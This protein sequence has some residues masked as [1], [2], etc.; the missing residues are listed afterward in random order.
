MLALRAGETVPESR[1]I[2]GVWGDDTPNMVRNAMQV[3]VAHWRRVLAEAG[4]S[5]TI[6][7]VGAGYRLSAERSAIDVFRFEAL[8]SRARAALGE[9]RFVV[10]V[11]RYDE[12]LGLWRGDPLQD[13]VGMPFHLSE[14][15]SLDG[16]RV[17]ALV[18]RVE[19][20]IGAGEGGELVGALEGLVVQYP[21]EERF[22]AQLMHALYRAGRQ[23]DALRAYEQARHD[24][25]EI[26]V[27]AG[28]LLRAMEQRILQQDPLLEASRSPFTPTGVSEPISSL[29]GRD[30]EVKDLVE[31]LARGDARVVTL[32]GPGGVGKSRLA[33]E[34]ANR[35]Q[36]EG[37]MPVAYV[38]VSENADRELLEV[39]VNTA[40]GVP[41]SWR[42]RPVGDI[43][44]MLGQVPV[45]VVLDGAEHVV[46]AAQ[47]VV[48]ELLA[49]GRQIRVLVASRV[50]LGLTGERQV[51]VQPL[52]CRVPAGTPLDDA[53]AV[54]LFVDR[55]ARFS[56]WGGFDE[57]SLGSIAEV[58]EELD[59]LPLA[60]ELAAARVST[61]GVEGLLARLS[62]RLDVVASSRTSRDTRH[63]SLREVIRW[64]YD[65]LSP[66]AQELFRRLSI[67]AGE[68]SVLHAEEIS[69]LAQERSGQQS[70]LPAAV[71]DAFAELEQHSL[72]ARTDG[73]EAQGGEAPRFRFLRT[74]REFARNEL[75]A[76]GTTGATHEDLIRWVSQRL[77]RLDARIGAGAR[78]FD[79][80]DAEA[81]NARGAVQ[82]ALASNRADSAGRLCNELYAWW[83][84]CGRAEE[85]GR[86][87]VEALAAAK[88]S[89]SVERASC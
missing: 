31:L 11:E 56:A 79:G 71:I 86:W 36:S 69:G 33:L 30:A 26:G 67:F 22:R 78:Q 85:L 42:E 50:P 10:A 44:R 58:C 14:S 47:A 72:L 66:A 63:Q 38:R 51:A 77:E 34:V 53:P 17:Q 82:W 40:F 75:A 45:L 2:D 87:C 43:A 19:A 61:L 74:V 18:E 89:L 13:F 64:S 65:L 25:Q 35:V 12:A 32:T 9:Q 59:G 1:I 3:Y 62:D 16:A 49:G 37:W 88:S 68:F 46:D 80:I 81:D 52:R 76:T 7:R 27:D 23:V 20:L 83:M 57:R 60:I 73:A 24:L 6:E 41:V 39:S 28:P 4:C 15:V 54:A 84:T 5:E 70:R 21:Y 55:A 48:E 8:R 29:V